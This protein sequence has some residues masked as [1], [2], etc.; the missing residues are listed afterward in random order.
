MPNAVA[1]LDVL[2]DALFTVTDRDGARERLSLSALLA[3]L[4]AGP[5]VIQFS[6]IAGEQRSYW[7]RFL[8]R[9]AAKALHDR[10]QTVEEAARCSPDELAADLRAA[11]RAA[12]NDTDGSRGVWLL[13]Q[14]NH[15]Q[16]GFLQHPVI[17]GEQ[18]EGRKYKRNTTSILTCAIGSKLHDRKTEIARTMDA[19]QLVYGLIELQLGA[20]FGGKGNYASQIMGSAV[21]AGSGSPF[22]GARLGS[23]ENET[24]R[25]DL[26]VLLDSWERIREDHALRGTIWSLWTEPW[27][28]DHSL[29]SNKLD[30]AFIPLARSIRI[31]A[32]NADGIFDTTW[33][34]SSSKSRVKDLTGGGNFGDPFTP[35][36]PDA[37]HPEKLK[38]R[39]TL[40]NGYG[41]LEITNLLFGTDDRRPATLSPSVKALVREGEN[42]R[43][44]VRVLFEGTAFE[45]GKTVGFH[46]REILLHPGSFEMLGNP[47]PARAVHEEM[48]NMVRNAK[49]ALRGAV[50]ILL[51]G[52]AKPRE[53]DDDK[54][55]LPTDDLDARVDR[56][57]LD[58]LLDAAAQYESNDTSWRVAWARCL[59]EL[60]L[61]SFDATA[62]SLP[63]ATSRRF[64]RE[65][66]ARSRLEHRLRVIRSSAG[67]TAAITQ[68]SPS[69]EV[70]A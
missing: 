16:P 37:K 65:A 10:G 59:E 49:S 31:G 40:G 42:E 55:A 3:R 62:G 46:R 26:S 51:S 11:L 24:F 35:L 34:R 52:T 64:E 13:H 18:P 47:A 36:V 58:S 56:I 61:K 12:A 21:G 29:P 48:L 50:R 69:A 39:G 33:F 32:P 1:G 45:Q 2:D 67:D 44:D 41:Y 9:C 20:I 68:L 63:T 30:P 6:R 66:M 43:A 57:Y 7:W 23:A 22:M 25:H 28:G 14:P 27:S 15:A 70:P 19:E 53:G 8:V 5:D 4:L 38:V 17:D 54:I 60:A